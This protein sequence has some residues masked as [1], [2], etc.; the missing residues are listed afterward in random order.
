MP[1]IRSEN[2]DLRHLL[3]GSQRWARGSRVAERGIAAVGPVEDPMFEI[4][5][6][7]DRLGRPLKQK[8]RRRGD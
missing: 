1:S 8:Q 6:E 3:R 2:Q 4:D 7:I 5:L